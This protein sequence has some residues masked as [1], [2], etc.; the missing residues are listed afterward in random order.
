MSLDCRLAL[1]TAIYNHLVGVASLQALIGN[2]ARI[3]PAGGVPQSLW[4]GPDIQFP[5]YIVIG[6][7]TGRDGTIQTKTEDGQEGET[8]IHTWSTQRSTVE[9]QQIQAV[10]TD[11]IKASNL[12]L[13]SGYNLVLLF[14][15]LSST[16]DDQSWD[17][18]VMHGVNRWQFM[19]ERG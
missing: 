11:E 16:F 7:A 9:C 10:L 13:A 2:P 19:V 4:P 18:F 1:N 17:G 14:A 12:T 6:G 8:E 5:P 3:Y 15:T